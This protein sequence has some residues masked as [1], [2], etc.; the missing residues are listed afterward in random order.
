V[1]ALTTVVNPELTQDS[2]NVIVRE[3]H[4]ALMMARN[5]VLGMDDR[6]EE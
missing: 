4:L 3:S 6:G 2:R 1:F 5:V